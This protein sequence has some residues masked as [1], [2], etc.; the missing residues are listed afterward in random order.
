[1]NAVAQAW[2][3]H[4]CGRRP[5]ATYMTEIR[6]RDEA[7][8]A[9]DR[10]L[11]RW[12]AEAAGTLAQAMAA[13]TGAHA[14]AQAETTRRAQKVA[15]IE[16][17]LRSLQPD[18]P[19]RAQ[20]QRDLVRAQTSLDAARRATQRIAEVAPQVA[21]LQHSHVRTAEPTVSAAR[22]DVSRRVSALDAYRAART[23]A[24]VGAAIA[25]IVSGAL[26]AVGAAGA[27]ALAAVTASPASSAPG[28]PTWLARCGLADI[29]VAEADFSDNPITGS[30][31]R[32]GLTRAD[33]RWAVTTWD[34]VVR[35]GLDR[36][37]SRDDFA[38]RDQ[39]RGAP[40]L[41]RT[42]DVYDMILGSDPLRVERRA[43]GTLNVI[44]G[45]RRIEIASELG[46]SH[47]PAAAADP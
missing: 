29:K 8:A 23:G 13:A 22:A 18:D 1:M 28:G 41:R 30:F 33:Y 7:L 20:V 25:G 38:A 26:G 36:G 46:I 4:R 14:A 39:T 27:A 45:R 32:G 3:R 44:N 43:D 12:A 37:M 11:V 6:T 17:L 9:I 19:L 2:P 40:P 15:T 5:D 34:Q 16:A 47:L 21:R 10:A 35:P 24:D 42:A 31:G